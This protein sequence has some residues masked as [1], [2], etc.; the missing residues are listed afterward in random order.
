VFDCEYKSLILALL[1]KDEICLFDIRTQSVP[2]CKHEICVLR[3]DS[4]RAA[5]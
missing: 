3:K 2:R 5:L 1:F 4:V